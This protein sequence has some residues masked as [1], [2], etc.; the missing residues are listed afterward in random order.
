MMVDR[1]ECYSGV[2]YPERPTAISYQGQ[3]LEIAQVIQAWRIPEGKRFRVQTT[4]MQVFELVYKES[5]N[6]WL[7]TLIR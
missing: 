2:E 5:E 4:D 7:I 1:V 6:D 3:R